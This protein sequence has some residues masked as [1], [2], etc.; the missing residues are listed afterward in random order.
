MF[1]SIYLLILLFVQNILSPALGRYA[2][3]T[4][5]R[6]T[7]P[8]VTPSAWVIPPADIGIFPSFRDRCQP[9]SMG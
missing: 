2:T 6:F 5:S 4:A 1:S 7:E 8:R 3:P 9:G